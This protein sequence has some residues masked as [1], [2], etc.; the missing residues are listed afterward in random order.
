M[1]P[2]PT[3]SEQSCSLSDMLLCYNLFICSCFTFTK[4]NKQL[5]SRDMALSNTI[6]VPA[7]TKRYLLVDSFY[8]LAASTL[9]CLFAFYYILISVLSLSLEHKL[10]KEGDNVLFRAQ[11]NE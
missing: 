3:L 8:H 9:F 2:S 7:L 11:H 6:V 10:F 5:S 4:S 1:K